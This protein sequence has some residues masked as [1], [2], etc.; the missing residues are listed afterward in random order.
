MYGY[1]ADFH[2]QCICS[3]QAPHPY[4]PWLEEYKNRLVAI[5]KS[6]ARPDLLS[7][8]NFKVG[9]RVHAVWIEYTNGDQYGYAEMG[10]TLLVGLFREAKT[11]HELSCA[12]ECWDPDKNKE[13]EFQTTDG[14]LFHYP[15]PPWHGVYENLEMIYTEPMEIGIYN[16]GADYVF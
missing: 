16:I 15:K 8:N 3:E 12:L 5:K 10:G 9:E 6:N 1:D 2:K 4:G 14:Q 13:F 7:E 11:A